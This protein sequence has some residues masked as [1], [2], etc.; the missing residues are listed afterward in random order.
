MN[1]NKEFTLNLRDAKIFG[2]TT[3]MIIST[4]AGG[5]AYSSKVDTDIESAMVLIED[6]KLSYQKYF[7]K[8]YT[9]TLV[10][11]QVDLHIWEELL[12]R[13]QDLYTNLLNVNQPQGTFNIANK[14]RPYLKKYL[15]SNANK[16]ETAE[17]LVN[18]L[19][20]EVEHSKILTGSTRRVYELRG[21]KKYFELIKEYKIF[22][23]NL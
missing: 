1:S 23:E 18:S 2:V 8:V 4:L 12:K 5:A 11:G 22:V 3:I 9:E 21:N 14:D 10:T 6:S 19:R 15:Q 16:Q 20:E 17:R 7:N 13:S